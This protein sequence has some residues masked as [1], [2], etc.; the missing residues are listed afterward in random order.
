MG[1]S[2]TL[3]VALVIVLVS[4][5]P[6]QATTWQWNY[7]QGATADGATGA[8][9]PFTLTNSGLMDQAQYLGETLTIYTNV[10]SG[11]S[12]TSGSTFIGYTFFRLTSMSLAGGSLSPAPD[13]TFTYGFDHEI[14]GA[15]FYTGI[16]PTT[17]NSVFDAQNFLITSANLK[18]FFDAGTGGCPQSG[19]GCGGITPSA[20]FT[21]ANFSA[22][23]TFTD[24][25]NVESGTGSGSGVIGATVADGAS[26]LVFALDDILHTLGAYDPFE[27]TDPQSLDMLAFT[28]NNNQDC[29]VV[30]GGCAASAASI[31]A[32]GNALFGNS[33]SL[34]GHLIALSQNDGSVTKE[35]VVPLPG[36]LL[37]LGLGLIA[38]GFCS[39]R[40]RKIERD[41]IVS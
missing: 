27:L 30:I 33:F 36:S 3:A 9:A 26:D 8:L 41:G 19:F 38:A 13:G 10:A 15:L 24:G 34:A 1:R 4:G 39:G 22:L 35:A 31:L 40:R 18:L 23:G 12:P 2:V 20:G 17:G 32:A 5:G 16:H 14:T 11:G 29:G 25:V 28:D 6:A 37:L 21:K 7:L